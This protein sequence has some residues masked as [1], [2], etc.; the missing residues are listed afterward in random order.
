MKKTKTHLS[1]ANAEDPRPTRQKRSQQTLDLLAQSAESALRQRTF[2]ELSIQ[3]IVRGAG[4]TTGAFYARFSAKDDLLKYLENDV[5]QALE[6]SAARRFE[7]FEHNNDAR[8]LLMG[9]LSDLVGLYDANQGVFRAMMERSRIDS[10]LRT[11][12]LAYNREA[13]AAVRSALSET[14]TGKVEEFE[15]RFEIGILFLLGAVREAFLHKEFFPQSMLPAKTPMLEGLI[16][17]FFTFM[18]HDP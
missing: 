17:A 15:A 7:A 2:D 8:L 13:L 4:V 6:A 10:D 11:R 12:R 9:M 16:D 14:P 18:H 5:T 1:L 3:E